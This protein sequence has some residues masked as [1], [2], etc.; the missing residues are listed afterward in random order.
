[1]SRGSLAGPPG[2]VGVQERSPR[3]RAYGC[4]DRRR[5]GAWW[6]GAWLGHRCA[7]TCKS[8][9]RCAQTG[10][11]RLDL[12]ERVLGLKARHICSC[13]TSQGSKKCAY[14]LRPSFMT[15]R[16]RVEADASME[17]TLGPPTDTQAE[18]ITRYH[19]TLVLILIPV[20]QFGHCWCGYAKGQTSM[21]GTPR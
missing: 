3:S 13:E 21:P 16:C 9:A 20:P 5:R 4:G 6:T 1:M 19:V 18:A 11:I 10:V 17:L 2:I 12:E 7:D 15:L 14:A 8:C